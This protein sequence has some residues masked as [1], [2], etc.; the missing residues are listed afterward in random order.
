MVPLRSLRLSGDGLLRTFTHHGDTEDTKVVQ[1]S[2]AGTKTDDRRQ[3]PTPKGYP[4]AITHLIP[5]L[6]KLNPGLKLANT[7]GVTLEQATLR[8][9]GNFRFLIIAKV[10]TGYVSHECKLAK[11]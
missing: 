9:E 7:F 1:S 10:E 11:G 2:T 4:L 6:P 8:C 5:G 3:N